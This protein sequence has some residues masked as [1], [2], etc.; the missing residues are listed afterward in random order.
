MKINKKNTIRCGTITGISTCD[1]EEA[2]VLTINHGWQVVAPKDEFK[3][4]EEVVFIPSGSWIPSTLVPLTETSE[5]KGIKGGYLPMMKMGGEWSEGI[6]LK[7]DKWN[8]NDK[9]RVWERDLPEEFQPESYRSYP[10]FI[11][12]VE[13]PHA[14]DI[15]DDLFARWYNTK[16]EVTP[17]LNGIEMTVFVKSGRFGICSDK[18]SIDE[19][20][21][22]AF[23]R[24]AYEMNLPRAMVDYRDYYAI[25]GT[26]VGDGI[27]NNT[28]RIKGRKFYIHDI[29]DIE[30]SE[31][32][33]PKDRY[34]V[35]CDLIE[36]TDNL[37]HVDVYNK[38]IP[39]HEIGQ[40]MKDFHEYCQ[41]YKDGRSMYAF[42]KRKG[43]VFK[44]CDSQFG[45]KLKSNMFHFS[46]KL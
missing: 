2:E 36:D 15:A 30:T 42:S 45:F 9:A 46:N 19:S 12:K 26:I 16:F 22:D 13:Y 33:L 39:L 20:A 3:N 35:F 34:K 38:D 18:Y 41:T 11:K 5:Y 8:P 24:L 37:C 44:S 28:E 10:T 29:Y 27:Y 32:M 17:R 40:E 21:K 6:V 14:Q 31:F 25:H 4:N 43:M 1:H 23:W 7:K